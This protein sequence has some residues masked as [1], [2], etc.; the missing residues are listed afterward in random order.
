MK[1]SLKFSR[2]AYTKASIPTVQL[3]RKADDVSNAAIR[4]SR[5]SLGCPFTP[6]NKKQA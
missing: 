4:T 6:H 3:M 5:C 2:P 1:V